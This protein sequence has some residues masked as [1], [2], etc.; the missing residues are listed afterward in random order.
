MPKRENSQISKGDNYCVLMPKRE[1]GQISKGGNYGILMP[2]R[3][4]LKA[5]QLLRVMPKR[6]ERYKE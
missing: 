1:S 3:E 4:N 2:K 5:R 6:A